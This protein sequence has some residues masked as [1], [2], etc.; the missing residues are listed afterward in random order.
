MK[1]RK[2]Y[3]PL[4]LQ[5]EDKPCVIIGG[6]S[7]AERKAEALLEAGARVT[8]ISP[9]CTPRLGGWAKDGTIKHIPSTYQPGMQELANALLVFAATNRSEVNAAIR[10]EAEAMGKLVN[11]AD[12]SEGSGFIVPATVRRGRLLIAVS[13]AGAS[14]A[15]ARKVKQQ[16]E[17]TFGDEYEAYLDLLQE[18]RVFVQSI[19]ED[20][21]VRQQWFRHMLEWE[22][23]LLIRSG[24]LE[25]PDRLN[26]M[27]MIHKD[28][29]TEGMERVK[30]WLQSRLP[31]TGGT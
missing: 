29:T 20:T 7:V 22:L 15:A 4:M 9:A 3:Y 1:R 24:R 12:D 19:V 16:L 8:V 26:L 13:T 18:L 23:L 28:P 25:P 21:A 14:P 27:E 2:T 10:M 31:S 5:A 30:D 6:G 17:E 11:V